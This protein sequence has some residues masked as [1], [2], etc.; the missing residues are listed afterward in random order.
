MT[1][2][3]HTSCMTHDSTVIGR[4][5]EC[6]ERGLQLETNWTEGAP[7]LFNRN[8]A[9]GETRTPNLLIRSQML[10][11][12]ELRAHHNDIRANRPYP[13]TGGAEVGGTY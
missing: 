6:L 7:V 10:Y 5:A 1:R 8:G 11:P 12:I 2:R 9:P 13:E 3:H 4:Y